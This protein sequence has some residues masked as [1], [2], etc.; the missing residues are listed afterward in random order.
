MVRLSLKEKL[1]YSAG[2][3]GFSLVTVIHMLYLVFFFFPPKDAGIPYMIPQGSILGGFTVLGLIMAAGRFIDAITDPLIASWSDNFKGKLGKR[4]PFMRRSAL[5]FAASYALVFFVPMD[6]QV[7]G[8]NIVWVGLWLFSAAIFLTL[9]LVPHGSLMVEMAQH[10][11]D[12]IDLATLASVFWF[13]GFL[14]VSFSTGMWDVFQNLLGLERQSAIRLTFAL[15][16]GLGFIF[17]MVPALFI[18]EHRYGKSVTSQERQKLFPAMAKVLKNKDFRVFLTANTLYT[19]ATYIFETGMIYYITV[20]AL[21]KASAQGPLT[22]IIGAVVL[23]SYPLVNI[24]AKKMGKKILMLIGFLLFGLMF[25]AISLLGLWGI[26][27]IVVMA[28]VVVFAPLP[29]SIFGMLPGA[30]TADCAAY[31]NKL[32][33]EDSAGMYVAVN[34]FIHKL[35]ASLATLLF[36]SF[37]LLGKD[38]GD[39]L[40]IRMATL[41]AAVLCIAGGFVLK[42]YD[43]KRVLSYYEEESVENAVPHQNS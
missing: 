32:T 1:I 30:M 42:F 28:L 15:I 6:G 20:L 16:A 34:G 8:I 3:F 12:K 39:D 7:H 22:T 37:L 9:Y 4:I 38:A 14:V 2:N 25:V 23:L 24:I 40:G 11:D 35:G 13:I 41:F 17:L 10:P 21:W 31:D 36:T 27:V 18:D 29:Q 33:G 19:I 5:G 26:P 43:E